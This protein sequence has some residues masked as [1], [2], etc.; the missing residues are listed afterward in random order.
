MA[1]TDVR[2]SEPARTITI[3]IDSANAELARGRL[4]AA[5]K[6]ESSNNVTRKAAREDYALQ[7]IYSALSAVAHNRGYGGH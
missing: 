3:E 1:T 4:E 5:L 7:L 2:V 6:D